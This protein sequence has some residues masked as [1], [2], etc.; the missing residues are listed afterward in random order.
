M[1]ISAGPFG[2]Q[3]CGIALGLVLQAVVSQ[4]GTGN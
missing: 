1:H 3:R 4:V 2:S